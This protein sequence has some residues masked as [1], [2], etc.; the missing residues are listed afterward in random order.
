MKYVFL[1]LVLVLSSCTN[2]DNSTS[3]ADES[4]NEL[5][6]SNSI[7]KENLLKIFNIEDSGNGKI[8]K[9]IISRKNYFVRVTVYQIFYN[10]ELEELPL[11]VVNYKK[12]LFVY[13]N[14]A[15]LIFHNSLKREKLCEMLKKSGI[16]LED[17]YTKSYDS[18]VLQF[19]INEKKE[20][21]INFPAISPFDEETK[22]LWKK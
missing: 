13:Y 19:D 18:R 15:E 6:F 9:V 20:I 1:T 7:I 16:T 11:G 12:N 10:S 14:G 3:K 21:K 22:M 17:S 4:L 2:F 8:F 5:L